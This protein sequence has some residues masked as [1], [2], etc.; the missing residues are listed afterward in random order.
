MPGDFKNTHNKFSGSI[1]A[2]TLVFFIGGL[3]VAIV[4]ASSGGNPIWT[5]AAVGLVLGLFLLLNWLISTTS[6]TSLRDCYR[7]A[8]SKRVR[9]EPEYEPRRKAERAARYGE[10]GPP[11][12][13]DLKELKDGTRSWVPSN[14]RSG[15]YRSN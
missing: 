9:P 15:K 3:G 6:A 8:F 4:V 13:D 1:L 7:W 5:F 2:S 10:K 12:A 14:T 11:S